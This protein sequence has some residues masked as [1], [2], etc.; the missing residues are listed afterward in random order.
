MET[1]KQNKKINTV[2]GLKFCLML[3]LIAV[4][5]LWDVTVRIR[6]SKENLERLRGDDSPT[7]FLFW[8]NHLF[9]ASKI[10][11]LVASDRRMY[12]LVSASKDGAWLDA[13]FR[14]LDFG[15]IRGS[16]NFRGA[17][18]LKDMIRIV[19]SGQNIGI[20]PDGSK[21]PAYVL[22]PGAAAVAKACK[23]RIVLFG[24]EYQSAWRLKSWDRFFVPKPFTW[25][26]L[27]VEEFENYSALEAEDPYEAAKFMERRLRHLQPTD[28]EIP[29]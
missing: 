17:Q 24:I 22:K 21:G 27:Q 2:V 14:W 5:R 28:P 23:C 11:R 1:A 26:K 8:H 18:A 12:A 6:I 29:L 20:T 4:F 16:A 19:R 7:L 3:P 13:L 15:S 9:S 10:K 25:I